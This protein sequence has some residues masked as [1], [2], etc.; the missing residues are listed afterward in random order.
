MSNA[1]YEVMGLDLLPQRKDMACWYASARMLL[2]WK[3]NNIH[4]RTAAVP[5]ELDKASQNI[6]EV[7]NGI[8]NP[9]VIQLSKLL[10]LTA[11]PPMSVSPTQIGIWLRR[12]G[13]LWVNGTSHIVVIGGIDGMKVKVYDPWPVNIGKI[14]WRSLDGWYVGGS[15]SSRD[16]SASVQT[17]FLHC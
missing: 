1:R 13:P 16:I 3:D 5:L 7:N 11:V 9:Q 10:G 12:Y 2:S 4:Q 15:P 14:E 17:V 6:R 8:T